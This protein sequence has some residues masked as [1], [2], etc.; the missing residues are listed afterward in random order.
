MI[1]HKKPKRI[2]RH[3][4]AVA[5]CATLGATLVATER[6]AQ[7]AIDPVA[8]TAYIE[9]VH[10]GVKLFESITG[11]GG[12]AGDINAKLDAI[13]D[14][15]L[16]AIA[17][18]RYDELE[19]QAEAVFRL[20]AD[21]SDNRPGNA[22]NADDWAEINALQNQVATGMEQIIMA[23]SS[24]GTN[25]LLP[26][27]A[28][29]I[30]TGT[31]VLAIKRELWPS[32]PVTWSSWGDFYRWLQPGI[33][34]SYKAIG[35]QRHMCWDGENPGYQPPPLITNPIYPLW[36][37]KTAPGKYQNSTM[38]KRLENR[39]IHVET[40]EYFC[41]CGSGTW[42]KTCNPV[43]GTCNTPNPGFILGARTWAGCGT[44]VSPVACAQQKAKPHF[45]ANAVV[46]VARGAM[47]ST[48]KLSGGNDFDIDTNDPWMQ[49]G[50]YVDPWIDEPSCS[51]V[52]GPWAYPQQ[53]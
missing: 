36:V 33:N 13:K 40:W 19:A 17:Q 53:P 1:R 2:R 27:Y 18:A 5:L 11:L 21:I 23:G 47:K 24:N 25:A 44:G 22:T 52:N 31:G 12:S 41:R 15:I 3:V 10:A 37:S 34:A 26:G 38:W 7:A 42:Q 50:G 45:D 29:L 8:I 48:Q 28:T 43:S 46:K 16:A 6:P 4:M 39:S 49:S 35:S 30:A 32:S 14:E 51:S 9:M 20:F